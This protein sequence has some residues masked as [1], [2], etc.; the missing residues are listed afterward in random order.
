MLRFAVIAAVGALGAAGYAR[1]VSTI[2]PTEAAIAPAAELRRLPVD[3][4]RPTKVS[5]TAAALTKSADGHFW[6]EGTVNGKRVRF[7]VDTGASAVA[8]TLADARRLGVTGDLNYSVEVSTANGKTRAAPVTLDTVSVAGARV[9]G[10]Q[11][12]VVE[13]G[14]ETS[15][16][17]M[18][19]LG[20]LSRFEATPSALILR[21]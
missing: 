16:L 12:F 17:G 19:Y 7:L 1:A 10:V 14:L 13:D 11:A 6:A 2:Q 5:A 21:P 4:L 3:D 20:R 18:S 9:A 15:L 8:L